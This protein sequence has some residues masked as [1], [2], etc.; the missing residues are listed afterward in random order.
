MDEKLNNFEIFTLNYFII[1]ASLI[2]I[3]FNSLVN[4]LKQDCWTIPIL[5]IL[6]GIIFII[7]LYE[8]IKY[9]PNLNISEKILKIF[10]KKIA[11]VILFLILVFNFVMTVFNLLNISIFIQ[12][13]FLNKT[14]LIIIIIMI[15]ITTFYIL[16]KGISVIARTSNIL[17][18]VSVFLVII[19]FIGLIP[20]FKI[21]NIKP[22]F[23]A[24]LSDYSN[25]ISIF[26]YFNIIP[27]FMLTSIPKVTIKK[28]K[29]KRVLIISFIISILSIFLIIFQTL[30]TFGYKLTQLYEYPEFFALKHVSLANLSSRVES[31]L[32]TQ[33]IFD[34]IIYN[35]FSIYF[36]NSIIKSTFKIN[37]NGLIYLI[38]SIMIIFCTQ[39]VSKYNLLIYRNYASIITFILNTIFITF[40]LIFYLKIKMRK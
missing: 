16:T 37:K 26:C 12:S 32:I 2:G 13:Q 11:K 10:N 30:A 19:S 20:A 6:P 7:I 8:I 40:I 23:T 24:S 38:L 21:E 25:G 34:M 17:F 9:K 28:P 5:S 33:L 36:M 14:P 3:T 27:M 22:F 29:I 39:I 18:Y 15:I 4:I 1:R 31:I 35:I